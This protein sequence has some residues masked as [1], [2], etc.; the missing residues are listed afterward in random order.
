VL[1]KEDIKKYLDYTIEK[2]GKNFIELYEK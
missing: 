2:Y 1:Y